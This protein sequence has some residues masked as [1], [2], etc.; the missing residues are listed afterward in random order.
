MSEELETDPETRGQ[1]HRK[2]THIK[3][4]LREKYQEM[5][6]KRFEDRRHTERDP[7][8]ETK[9]ERNMDTEWRAEMERET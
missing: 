1:G 4:G 9:T 3:K 2:R 5:L 6:R 7:E 8:T